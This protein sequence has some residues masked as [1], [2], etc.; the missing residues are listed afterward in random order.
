MLVLG[1]WAQVALAEIMVFLEG[2][3]AGFLACGDLNDAAQLLE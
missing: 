1:G 2:G 3:Q